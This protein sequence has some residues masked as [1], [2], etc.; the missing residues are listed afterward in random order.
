MSHLHRETLHA[1]AVD[2]NGRGVLITGPA[3][4]GKSSLT[5][6]LISLGARLT[7]DDVVRLTVARR[8]LIAS[9][10]NA[11]NR[12]MEL[13][14]MGVVR[15]SGAELAHTTR[16]CLAVDLTHQPVSR[17]PE[18]ETIT[19]LGTSLPLLR[20]KGASSASAIKLMLA[21]GGPLPTDQID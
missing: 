17:L 20:A 11:A 19:Y 10:P 1:S 5:A 2:L 16:L 21:H 9:A 6:A 13:R 12:R 15:L 4:S 18:L 8:Q 3:G 14:G 7:A